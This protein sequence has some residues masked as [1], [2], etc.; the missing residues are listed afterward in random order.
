M[1]FALEFKGIFV[2]GLEIAILFLVIYGILY[3]L[4]NTRTSTILA[5]GVIGFLLLSFLA[6]W[7]G[8]Q[9]IDRLLGKLGD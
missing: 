9:V 4:R 7:L 8:L 2:A 1:N 5:G 3:Y 6:S